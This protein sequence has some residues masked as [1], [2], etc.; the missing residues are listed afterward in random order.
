MESIRRAL[1]MH[2]GQFCTPLEVIHDGGSEFSNGGVTELL[3]MC[4][5]HNAK[6][7]AYSKEEN[8]MV[9]RANKEVMRHLRN[10]LFESNVTKNWEDHL[11]TIM[12]IMNHQKRGAHFPSPA[13]LLFGNRLRQ[14][15][16]MFIPQSAMIV[17]GAQLQL[18]AWA[19][20]MIMQQHTIVE[21]AQQIQNEKD[22]AH[23]AEQNPFVTEFAVGSYVLANYHSTEGVVR[24]KG[25]P[26]KFLSFLRGP[27]KVIAKEGDTYTIRSLITKKDERIHVKELRQFIHNDDEKELYRTA[28]RDHQDHFEIEAILAHR[29]DARYRTQLEFLV[30]W[31][32]YDESEDLWLPYSELRDSAALHVYLLAQP[33]RV[34]QK[35]VPTKF[36]VDG[37]YAPE[38]D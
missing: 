6:T 38:V 22:M 16:P 5:I 34:M 1:L 36:F 32:G 14:D 9:E 21:L 18:S 2:I 19:C 13:S 12:K 17:D 33:T 10:V 8:G 30:R 23:L 35:L 15:E 26:N 24:H 4:G 3:A 27:L 25:P 31:R 11:G 37:V 28:L 20:N 29:G 7:L